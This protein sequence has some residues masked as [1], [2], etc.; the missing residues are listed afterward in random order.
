MLGDDWS[1]EEM[2][3]DERRRDYMG[4]QTNVAQTLTRGSLEVALT[5][6]AAISARRS[7]LREGQSTSA[8][9]RFTF[10]KEQKT[11]VNRY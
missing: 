6:L 9:S 4:S 11:I 7:W 10:W 8:E 3:L 5:S 1:E 2:G